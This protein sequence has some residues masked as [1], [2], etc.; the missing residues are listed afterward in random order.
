VVK[1]R[2]V[3]DLVCFSAFHRKVEHQLLPSNLLVHPFL[4]LGWMEESI[5]I[6][7]ACLQLGRALDQTFRHGMAKHKLVFEAICVTVQYHMNNG[8]HLYEV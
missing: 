3:T 4:K 2:T 1:F 6:G 5:L 7:S 8:S